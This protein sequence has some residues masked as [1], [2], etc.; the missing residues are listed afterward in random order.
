VRELTRRVALLGIG[1][2]MRMGVGMAL[3]GPA[4]ART[5]NPFGQVAAAYL[6]DIDGA[7][8]WQKNAAQRLAPASL[9]K[10][11]TALLAAEQLEPQERITVDAMAARETGSRLGLLPGDTFSARDLLAAT[12][13]ASANDACR[14]LADH[15]AGTQAAFVQRMNQRAQ[16][17]GLRNTRFANAC[18][19]DAPGH[20]SSVQ[21][22]RLLARA[23]LQQP[24]LTELVAQQRREIVSLDGL[25]SF[26][27][28]STNALL[29]RYE[30]AVGIKTGS[31]PLA[32][33]CLVAL[34]RRG[35]HSVL[36]VMLKGKDRWWDTADMLDI[37]FARANATP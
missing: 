11:M 36:L 9:T 16:Q 26:T 14:A 2:V 34:I 30:G 5:E 25:R 4:L 13:I 27:L 18:G 37:A 31:T 22:L 12:L 15:A 32:G 29:G 3:A 8:V 35:P 1:L 21:D 6:V 7:V 23:V 10:L 33:H 24:L 28:V 19:H 17:L 20:T